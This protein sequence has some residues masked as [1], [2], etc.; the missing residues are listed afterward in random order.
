[1]PEWEHN[2]TKVSRQPNQAQQLPSEHSQIHHRGD[3][4]QPQSGFR[5]RERERREEEEE[6]EEGQASVSAYCARLVLCSRSQTQQENS[7]NSVFPGTNWPLSL[8]E[9]VFGPG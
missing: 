2:R 6:Q 9:A 8:T 3:S 5:L 7:I 4:Q 1:M